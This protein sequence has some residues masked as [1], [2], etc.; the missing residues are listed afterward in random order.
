[1]LVA[2]AESLPQRVYNL[3]EQQTPTVGERLHG[4]PN[5]DDVTPISDDFDFRQALVFDTTAIRRDLGFREPV[6]YMTGLRRTLCS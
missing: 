3:G 5:R 2:L 6:P 1:M 4:L